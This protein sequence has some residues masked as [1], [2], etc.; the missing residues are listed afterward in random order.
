MIWGRKHGEIKRFISFAWYPRRLN[1]GQ[2]IWWEK[3]EVKK[4]NRFTEIVKLPELK[5]EE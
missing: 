1:N 4:I 5:N 2:W 3:V